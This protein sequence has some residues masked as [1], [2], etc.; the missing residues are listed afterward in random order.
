ML[1]KTFFELR[2][3]LTLCISLDPEE[4][5]QR[6]VYNWPRLWWGEQLLRAQLGLHAQDAAD[7]DGLLQVPRQATEDHKD[8]SSFRPGASS[9]TTNAAWQVTIFFLSFQN[10]VIWIHIDCMPFRILN[11]WKSRVQPTKCL[12]VFSQEIIFSSLN[13]KK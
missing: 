9:P 11:D 4:T 10:P 2:E 5:D 8:S 7:L 6:P 13:L 12:C 1:L 3:R